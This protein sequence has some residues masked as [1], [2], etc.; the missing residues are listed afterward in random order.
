[1]YVHPIHPGACSTVCVVE[2]KRG[3]FGRAA[4]T[5]NHQ[6]IFPFRNNLLMIHLT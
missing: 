5:F 6:I 4:D 1:M 3:S 2:P